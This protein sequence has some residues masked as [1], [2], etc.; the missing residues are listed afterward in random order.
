ML[1][2]AI[3]QHLSHMYVLV[4]VH[5]F[6]RNSLIHEEITKQNLRKND[7]IPEVSCLMHR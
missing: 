5:M 7:Y 2:L 6:D 3:A 1:G 4:Y